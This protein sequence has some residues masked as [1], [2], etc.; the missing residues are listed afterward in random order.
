MKTTK[1][2]LTNSFHN[3]TV[4]I[5]SDEPWEML[6]YRADYALMKRPSQRSAEDERVIRQVR[7]VEKTLCGIEGCKCGTVRS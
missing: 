6:L 3:T 4:T 7:R 1:L 2:T 5:H